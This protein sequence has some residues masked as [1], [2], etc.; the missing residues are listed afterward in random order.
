MAY[1]YLIKLEKPLGSH[2]HQ[3]QYYLGS[4][5]V[6]KKRLE[7]HKSGQGAA[8]LRAAVEKGIDFQIIRTWRV[9]NIAEARKLERQLKRQKNNRRFAKA[10]AFY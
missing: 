4:C 3:A 9:N 10:I 1:C 7:K 6:L 5:S 8:F 2:K